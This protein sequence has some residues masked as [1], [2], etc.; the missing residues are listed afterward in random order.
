[1]SEPPAPAKP[2]LKERLAK[3]FAEYGRVAVYLY[4]SISIATWFGFAL[5]FGL[6]LQ[7][8]DATG[9]L[10]CIG[11]GWLAGKGTIFIRIPI[12][13]AITP[14]VAELLKRRKARRIA[15][16]LELSDEQIAA[17]DAE[18]KG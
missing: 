8:T 18:D 12:T 6:G 13:L 14:P 10:G 1:M 3:L 4:F 2:T 11:A 9:V 5:A 16:G 7:P 17:L 15:A